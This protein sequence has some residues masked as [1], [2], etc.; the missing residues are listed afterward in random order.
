[1]NAV[2]DVPIVDRVADLRAAVDAVRRQGGSVGLVPT[3]GYLHQ[4]HQSLVT[5][6]AAENDLDRKSV[7]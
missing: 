6:S 3:M 4:G 2:T 1:M 5:C 7:V